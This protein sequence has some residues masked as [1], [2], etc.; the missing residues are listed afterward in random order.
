V[1]LLFGDNLKVH[2]AGSEQIDFSFV[3]HEA[4]VQY[5]L[6][7]C[8]PFISKQFGINGYP[9]TVKTAFP[10]KELDRMGKHVIMDSGLFTLMFGAHKGADAT[11]T[12]AFLS[13]WQDALID[14][15]KRNGIN[16]TCVEVDCQKILGV[17][18]AWE[19]RERFRRE[20]PN[21]QINV[22]HAED[23][24]DGL[25]RLIDFSDYIAISVPE[26]RLR[27]GRGFAEETYR[28]SCYIKNRK[29]SI[30]IHLLGCTQEDILRR[31]RFCTTS[32]S[33]SWQAC[34]RY[35]NIAGRHVSQINREILQQAAP[36][37][38]A[39]HERYGIEST[40]K[41]NRYYAN[42]YASAYFHKQLYAQYCGSQE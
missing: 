42:Y 14:F 9:I 41:R 30:D 38:L 32:D 2:F 15:V 8:F 11:R 23:G 28:L 17:R 33:T 26:L 16:A 40:E 20:L 34:N 22:F 1:E 29:P 36:H 13:S 35:G 12:K 27:N 7:T 18:E 4:G 3:A 21:R 19:F 6:F 37:V 25:D 39:M 5:F 31:C 24:R 10:P